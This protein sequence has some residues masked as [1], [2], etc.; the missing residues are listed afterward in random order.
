MSREQD[1][2]AAL[3][4]GGRAPPAGLVTWNGSDPAPRFAVYRNNVVAS[5]IDALADAFPVTQEL[6][7][8]AFFRAMARLYVGSEPPRSRVL[9]FYGAT[10]PAFIDQFPPAAGVPYLADVARLEML[11]VAAYHAADADPLA[12]EAIARAVADGDALLR[13]RIGLHPSAGVVQSRH[14]V[15]SVW[16]AHQGIGD[17]ADVD[18][19]VAEAAL[20]VRPALDVEVIRLLPS[21]GGFVAALLCGAR[22]ARAT[23][24]AA[25]AAPDF[26]LP[27]A[28]GVLIRAR[29]VV[30][31][32]S[33]ASGAS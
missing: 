23:E 12:A 32:D 20:V 29:A 24:Q 15:V 1:F 31:I 8:E 11:R 5:L 16:A 3:L 22:L 10:F 7:G 14:A 33:Q 9:A 2:Y 25:A 17:L 19:E 4:D 13:L 30:S 18:W 26:D 6:V 21:D 27:R 28:L